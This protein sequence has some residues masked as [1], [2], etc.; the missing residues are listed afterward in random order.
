MRKMKVYK[1]GARFFDGGLASLYP[2]DVEPIEEYDVS[3]LSDDEYKKLQDN[4]KDKKL[5][6]KVKKING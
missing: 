3:S 1:N 6:K 4:P 2:H 5:L